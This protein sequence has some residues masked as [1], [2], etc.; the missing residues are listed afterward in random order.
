[1][2]PIAK[3]MLGKEEEKAVLEVLR[4]GNLAQGAKVAEFE[5]AFA[6]YCGTKYA[7]ATNNGTT[8][9]MSALVAAGIGLGDEVITTPFTFAATANSIIFAGA[10][11][12]FVDIEP[13]TFNIDLE[14]IE[15]AIT[16]KTRALLPVH[17]YGLMSDMPAINK[18]AMNYKLIVI[19]DSAQ[20]HGANVNGKKAGSWGLAGCFSFYPTKN[21]TAGEGG[22]ITTNNKKFSDKV[23]TYRNQG[24]GRRYYHDVIG[25]NFRMTN[26]AAAIG[27]EQL[28]KLEGFTKK[29]IENATYLNKNLG[30]VEGVIRPTIPEG[31]RHVF[32]QYT[33]RLAN[34]KSLIARL[35]E[36]GVGYGIHYPLLLQRQKAFRDFNF[37][38]NTPVAERVAKE[39]IS[40]PVH[41]GLRKRDL[42][43]IVKILSTD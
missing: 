7:V 12:V 9:L 4:S 43:R 2:I 31:Y 8:A 15:A 22:M 3:P 39:V 10:K 40:L 29:R 36:A 21:M 25:Y 24:M 16:K 28:K 11:P 1:M 42:D 18:I 6:K 35:E 13:D 26:I 37:R 17:L 23:R 38:I 14:L 20:A 32:H 34:R 33:V 41:P 19:E 27:V 5:E 30:K